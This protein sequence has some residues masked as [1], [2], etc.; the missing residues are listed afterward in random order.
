MAHASVSLCT[1]ASVGGVLI[2]DN[3]DLAGLLPNIDESLL[4]DDMNLKD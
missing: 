4:L 3:A 1:D 2:A